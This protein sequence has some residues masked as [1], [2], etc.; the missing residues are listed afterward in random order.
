MQ[1]P[2]PSKLTH[3]ICAKSKPDI[4]WIIREVLLMSKIKLF[5]LPSTGCRIFPS[6]LRFTCQSNNSASLGFENICFKRSITSR[7]HITRAG[8]FL[9]RAFNVLI[10]SDILPLSP[11]PFLAPFVGVILNLLT[12]IISFVPTS[13]EPWR[14]M[15]DFM[16][17]SVQDAMVRASMNFFYTQSQR[18]NDLLCLVGATRQTI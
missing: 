14:P 1:V 7:Y 15:F 18:T 9:F 10:R 5:P 4:S 13:I 17:F 8:T 11:L 16:F 6:V 3:S 12:I 2:H